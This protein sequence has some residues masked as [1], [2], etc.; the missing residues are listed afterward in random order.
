MERKT[1]P[2]GRK[3]RRQEPPAE[4]KGSG[5]AQ[6]RALLKQLIR[7]QRK[8]SI[9]AARLV[10]FT[11]RQLKVMRTVVRK[12][13]VKLS[14]IADDLHIHPRTLAG[15]L[16]NIYEILKVHGRPAMTREAVRL[17]LV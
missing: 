9:R 16:H 8:T 12:S 11:K 7:E 14:V 13:D 5:I 4:G 10:L 15:H 3:R 1:G 2:T 17:G 6:L